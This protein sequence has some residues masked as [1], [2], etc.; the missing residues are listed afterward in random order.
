MMSSTMSEHADQPA[1][2]YIYCVTRTLSGG[3]GKPDGQA[4]DV[5]GIG[6]KPVRAIEYSDLAAVVS[7]STSDSY[8]VTRENLTAH[9]QVVERVMNNADVLPVSFG[10]V[11]TD[12]QTVQQQLLSAAADDLHRALD[13]V[14]ER[15]ELGV[16]IIWEKDRLFADLASEDPTIQA[17]LDQIAGS[18]PEETYDER[19]QLGEL[20]SNG[21][22]A[23]RDQDAAAI[24]N[25]LQPLAVDVRVNAMYADLMVLNASFLVDKASI[26]AFEAA[27]DA[28]RNEQAGRFIVQYTGPLPPYN[29][30]T[31]AIGGEGQSVEVAR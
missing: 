14:H 19:T 30:V 20:I 21:I 12:D 18:T 7:D 28:L 9:E 15:V 23:K 26:P 31:I 22:D 1:G 13:V 2:T 25:K 8:D 10:T 16:K 3:A 5:P 27:V 24:L 17:L 4:L 11:A 6:G 29:F